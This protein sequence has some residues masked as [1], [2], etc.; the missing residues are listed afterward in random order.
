MKKLSL[1]ALVAMLSAC[2][3]LPEKTLSGTYEGTLPCADCAKIEAK[4]VLNSDKTYQYNTVFFKGKEQHPFFE[5]GTYRWDSKKSDVIHLQPLKDQNNDSLP[6]ILLK[7]ADTHVELC[8]AEGN[9]AKSQHYRL[10]KVQ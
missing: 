3:M 9:T 4:L 8:D 7:V 2:S 10:Q 1:V 6:D 5:K